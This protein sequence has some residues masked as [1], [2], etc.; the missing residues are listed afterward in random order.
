MDVKTLINFAFWGIVAVGGVLV[1]RVFKRADH[2]QSY[3]EKMKTESRE[4]FSDLQDQI[5]KINVD[6]PSHYVTKSELAHIIDGL[7]SRLDNIDE[8]MEKRFNLLIEKLDNAN[9]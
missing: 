1:G 9:K 5:Y 8:K 4:K 2:L 6:L 7:Y 3:L